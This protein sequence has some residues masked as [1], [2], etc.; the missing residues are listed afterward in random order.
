MFL[1]YIEV[2]SGCGGLS[3]GLERAGFQPILLLDNDKNCVKTLKT[4]KPNVNVQLGD[5]RKLSLVPYKNNLSL[6]AGGIPCQSFSQAGKREGLEDDRGKLMIDF[7]RLITESLPDCFLIENVQGLVTHEKGKTLDNL[8]NILSCNGK[9]CIYHK[10]LNANDFGVAQKRKRVFIVGFLAEKYIRPFNFPQELDYKPTLKDVLNNCPESVGMS[11]SENKRKIMELVPPGGC[12]IDLPEEIKLQ[13]LG[14]SINSGGGKRGVARRL[15]MDEPS[16][17]LTTSPSQKQT[18]R[19]H[20][21]E[22][23]PLTVREYAR[24]QSFDDTYQFEGSILSQYKQIGNAVPPLL[25][26]HVG[27][28]IYNYLSSVN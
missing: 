23:R 3:T 27:K 6:L 21:N 12:W 10:V 18:E 22:T 28:A 16:L 4:N 24:I 14:S 20:P 7:S 5:M 26:Y 13:Y 2:C 15:S 9:Y 11:Y 19:C 1:N 8:K 17:T 25:A